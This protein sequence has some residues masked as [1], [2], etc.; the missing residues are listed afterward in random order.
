M[1]THGRVRVF[2]PYPSKSQLNDD[3]CIKIK[4][5]LILN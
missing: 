2:E 3:L 1:H 4:E 5:N